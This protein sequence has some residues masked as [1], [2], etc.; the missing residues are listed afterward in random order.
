MSHVHEVTITTRDAKGNAHTIEA[1]IQAQSRE[2]KDAASEV[3]EAFS[4]DRGKDAVR[5]PS[6][7]R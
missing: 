1:E 6:A 5:Y 3:L 7:D 2:C 4:K